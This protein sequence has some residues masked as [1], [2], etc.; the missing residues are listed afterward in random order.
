MKYKSIVKWLII[1]MVGGAVI[2]AA[3]FVEADIQIDGISINQYI[4]VN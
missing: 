2:S 1:A 4:N 3:S